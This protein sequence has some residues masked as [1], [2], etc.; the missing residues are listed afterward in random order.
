MD[1]TL[2]FATQATLSLVSF[3]LIVLVPGLQRST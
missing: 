3:G 2:V 1:G